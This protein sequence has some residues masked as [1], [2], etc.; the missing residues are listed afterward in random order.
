MAFYKKLVATG[1][2]ADKGTTDNY[3][4]P[5]KEWKRLAPHV[6]QNLILLDPFYH[7]GV[8]ASY[9]KEALQPIKIIHDNATDYFAAQTVPKEV[10]MIVTNPPFSIKYEVLKWLID[11]DKPFIS[12]FPITMIT[13]IK[14][15]KLIKGKNIKY[16]MP[17]GRMRFERNGV[18]LK[19]TSYYNCVWICRFIDLPSEFTFI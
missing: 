11:C 15:A 16:M 17:S 4:S 18:P 10:D 3:T 9:I 12:L 2:D 13:T 7:D 1:F 14:F 8:A 19:S 6:P 5:L